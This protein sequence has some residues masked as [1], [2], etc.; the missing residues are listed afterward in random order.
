MHQI[1]DMGNNKKSDFLTIVGK[2]VDGKLE[3]SYPRWMM[4]YFSGIDFLPQVPTT[5]TAH[6]EIFNPSEIVLNENAQYSARLISFDDGDIA[7]II[8]NFDPNGATE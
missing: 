6:Y 1:N 8:D 3:Y 2:Y 4:M 5:D 7:E